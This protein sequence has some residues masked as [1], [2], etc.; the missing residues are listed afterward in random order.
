MSFLG[1][2]GSG[3]TT[4]LNII[5]GFLAADRGDLWLDGSRL[6]Q[7]TPEQRNIG[8]VFQNYALFPHM[9]VADNVAFP[10]KMRKISKDQRRARVLEALEMVDLASMSRR[11]PRQLSGGQQQRVAL[12][13]ALAFQPPLL[14]M[15][16][17]LGA[18]DKNL[19]QSMQLELMKMSRELG[20][21]VVY[22]THDQ[23]EAL[24]MSGRIAVYNEGR[25]EQIGTPNEVYERPATLFVAGFVG[26]STIFSGRVG[27]SAGGRWLDTPAGRI[28]MPSAVASDVPEASVVLR[29]EAMD[30]TL[31]DDAPEAHGDNEVGL[32]GVLEEIVYLGAAVKLVVRLSGGTQ[33][34]VRTAAERWSA[35]TPIGSAVRLRWRAD[36]GV[37]LLPSSTAAD[38]VGGV[39]RKAQRRDA[40]DPPASRPFN[41][42]H[43]SPDPRT[44][45]P[46][47]S[48]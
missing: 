20:V 42:D 12:A 35:G 13:R 31:V 3:K 14:L 26:E 47:E 37:V 17:P 8:M 4:T 16:E 46:R 18:L 36:S 5:A 1:P 34:V 11:H 25:I 2:S 43:R 40:S 30:V 6:N 33:A 27:G 19:R 21:T 39:R 41:R 38:P 15:D 29:P 48:R 44:H 24:S 22:V 32:S 23:E 45:E 7:M 9:T 10:L 28:R